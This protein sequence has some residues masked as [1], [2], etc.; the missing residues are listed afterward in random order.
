MPIGKLEDGVAGKAAAQGRVQ[1]AEK[2]ES[3]IE[4]Q[5]VG[6]RPAGV[7]RNGASDMIA[8]EKFDVDR[9]NVEDDASTGGFNRTEHDIAVPGGPVAALSGPG[10]LRGRDAVFDVE[11]DG[12]GGLGERRPWT[13]EKKE[14]G[15]CPVHLNT[16]N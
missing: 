11:E 3:G 1:Q 14:G 12:R 10:G 6:D 15:V 16:Q 8:G 13:Q 5:G 2:G 4:D 7:G 9:E